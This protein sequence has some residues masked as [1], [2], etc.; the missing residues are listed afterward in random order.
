M[1]HRNY[2]SSFFTANN[3]IIT[4]LKA[5]HPHQSHSETYRVSHLSGASGVTPNISGSRWKQFTNVKY[6][7]GQGVHSL[8][9]NALAAPRTY[10]FQHDSGLGRRKYSNPSVLLRTDSAEGNSPADGGT[11]LEEQQK[12]EGLCH[13][14][15]PFCLNLVRWTWVKKKF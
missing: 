10:I 12:Q 15:C 1:F 2:W 14:C 11:V 5:S 13:L 7:L 3:H 4:G 9:G 6:S 8:K